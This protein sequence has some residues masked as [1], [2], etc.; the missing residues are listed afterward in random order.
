MKIELK[1]ES[2]P[3]HSKE[4]TCGH[5]HKAAGDP[6][7]AGELIF[8]IETG[9]GV[10]EV[11]ANGTG[12]ILSIDV[13]TGDT[14]PIGTVLAVIEGERAQ[15]AEKKE[16]S[17]FSYSIGPAKPVDRTL[18][19]NIA[20][21]GGGPGGYVAAIQAAQMGAS[22]ILVEQ[23]ALG[24]TCL[25]RGCIPTKAMIRSA[26]INH[27]I[28]NAD[29]FG[30][31][32]GHFPVDIQKVVARKDE[33]VK[34]LVQGIGYLLNKRGVT[35][36][37]GFG[38][39]ASKNTVTVEEKRYNTTITAENI[40]LATGSSSCTL[41]IP[42][43]F[44][45]NVLTSTDALALSELPDKLAII[46]GGVIGMEF[47]FLFANLG[48]EVTVL[49]FFP[50]ILSVFDTDIIETVTESARKSG[51]KLITGANVKSIL[52]NE[53]GGS[54]VVY[55]NDQKEK[56]DLFEN[57]L[58]AVGR[59]PCYEGLNLEE[60]GI[61]LTANK[62]GIE[63]DETL[64][65][66]VD[67]VYAIGDITN[68]IQL[69]HVASHQGVVAVKNI[70]GQCCAMDYSTIPNAVFTSPE[71][72]VVGVSER[73]AER[74][75]RKIKIGKFP[76]TAN[77]KALAYGEP[78][79]FVKLIEDAESGRLIGGAV[80]GPHATDMIGEI[81]LAIKNG[82]TAEAIT[83]TVHAHPTCAEGIHEAALDLGLGALHFMN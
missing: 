7:S 43:M 49:E 60:N 19:C 81:T 68:K 21:I 4:G 55:E 64:K 5:I 33:V 47:A 13:S 35:V 36:L 20:I 53:S 14:I 71:F 30:L 62:K 78:D 29:R 31:A 6:V 8:E 15:E 28:K 72:A 69:A 67:T 11:A 66:S 54:I 42:G 51:I 52:D 22:V 32:S 26:E 39:L 34:Q 77:G 2:L 61:A 17:A 70:M 73:N 48:V 74:E 25:N 76:F 65:T 46:G 56:Y 27:T 1:L 12:T 50:T 9:K 23:D 63:V 83:E 59:T 75:E 40:I 24:G 79:G 57:V 82:L 41:P 3:G 80:V 45:P 10:S 18:E 16:G 58:V 38:T 37:S 44:S